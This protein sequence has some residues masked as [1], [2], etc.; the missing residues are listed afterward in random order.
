MESSQTAAVEA[1]VANP[2]VPVTFAPDPRVAMGQRLVMVIIG[3][4]L[5]TAVHRFKAPERSWFTSILI[6]VIIGV[7][8]MVW[9]VVQ[10]KRK[11]IAAIALQAD[12][13]VI[14]NK[15]ERTIVPWNEIL[16]AER[17]LHGEDRWEFIVKNRREPVTYRLEGLLP[18]QLKSLQEALVQ[19]VPCDEVRTPWER[20]SLNTWA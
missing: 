19:R 7:A 12:A 11:G 16:K 4:V 15:T 13:L 18:P 2:A 9:F 17:Y 10:A 5:A 8:M 20:R 6:G 14:E 3:V 1:P